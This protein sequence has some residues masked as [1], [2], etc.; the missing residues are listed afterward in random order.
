MSAKYATLARLLKQYLRQ[1]L[2]E[3]D[4]DHFYIP[5]LPPSPAQL[6]DTLLPPRTGRAASVRGL[7][8]TSIASAPAHIA[9]PLPR[10]DQSGEAHIA[11]ALL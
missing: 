4:Y 3:G 5:R 7:S 1:Q 6:H 9:P 11:A 2:A 10:T 8:R